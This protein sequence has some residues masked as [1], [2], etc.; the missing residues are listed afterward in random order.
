MR[1]PRSDQ[2]NRQLGLQPA[3]FVRILGCGQ[4]PFSK[5]GGSLP[6]PVWCPVLRFFPIIVVSRA[7]LWSFQ[8]FRGWSGLFWDFP[9]AVA[10]FES[11]L[12]KAANLGHLGRVDRSREFLRAF[13][14]LQ[15]IFTG[16]PRCAQAPQ[17]R[18][19]RAGPKARRGDV[20]RGF[21]PGHLELG[22]VWGR[23]SG[24]VFGRFNGE[25]FG[26]APPAQV[27]NKMSGPRT[28][29]GLGAGGVERSGCQKRT[30]AP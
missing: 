25:V 30:L 18:S 6:D 26:R 11:K 24:E 17:S 28:K 3:K 14:L 19:P 5:T 9:A 10:E 16:W 29:R 13:G 2:L 22:F 21:P 1:R 27:M 23:F 15:P 20:R 7:C 8:A 4:D 12:R